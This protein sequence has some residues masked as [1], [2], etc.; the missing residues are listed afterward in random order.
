MI[1]RRK[2]ITVSSVAALW[3]LTG[4]SGGSSSSASSDGNDQSSGGDDT[5]SGTPTSGSLPIPKLLKSTDR[6]GIKH[7][8][9]NVIEN[10]HSFFEGIQTKTYAIDSTYL[11]PTLLL[12]NGDDVS[13]N[14]TNK[15]SVETTM[16]GHGMHVPGN[17][18][19]TAHQPIAV[20]AT[21]SAQYTVNQK[22]CTNWYHPHYLHKTAPH[23]YQGLAGM[24]II[25]DSES[26]TLDL[27]NR[28]GIDDIPLVLQDRFFTADKKALDYSPSNMQ[29]SRGYIGDTFICNGAIA[30]TFDAENKEI[31]FRLLNG[32]NS[33]VYDLGFSNA[34]SFKQIAS[35]N[36]FLENP[37][38]MSRITLSPGERA[39]I[40]VDLTE[41]TGTSFT[42]H[43]YNYD[44]TFLSVNINKS[45][46][47]SSSVPSVLTS[48]EPVGTATRKRKFTLGMQGMGNF[49]INNK[50]MD[51]NRIDEALTLGEVE[52]W[53]IINNMNVDHNFHIHATHFRL[54]SRNA[55]PAQVAENE[56]GYKDVAYLPAN[57]SMKFIVKMTDVTADNANPYMFHCHFLEHEDNGMMGQFTVTA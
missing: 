24:I 5:G 22:A 10:S 53:E 7:Y 8:D 4:C 56:K 57:E 19:G 21:W 49:T 44:Q 6:G 29:L 1:D 41:D 50:A 35:D 47:A 3:L 2:F 28:Y 20:G 52:E 42:L 15:L 11:G 13:I 36:A 46:T 40:V 33:T 31:R 34:K 39:E 27:P 30:P 32:S 51:Y 48:L 37:V 26:Q 23:V 25:E 12:K 9:L 54:I 43:E 45:A 55:V 38:T 16:H 14:Y 17:M 18:D